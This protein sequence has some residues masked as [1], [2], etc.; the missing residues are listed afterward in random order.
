[1]KTKKLFLMMIA[2][3]TITFA[4][5]DKDN[6]PANEGEQ[7]GGN[8]AAPPL[9]AASTQTWTFGDQ[10]WSDAILC[11]DCN[12]EALE[13]SYTAP[14]CR[15]YT[16][17]GKTRDY[18]NWAYVDANKEKMCLSPWRVPTKE[19]FQALRSNTTYSTLVDAWGY[20]GYARESSVSGL[21]TYAHYWSSSEN[22]NNTAFIL[23]YSESGTLGV[24]SENKRYGYQVRCVK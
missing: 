10:T 24:I 13:D 21:S 2:A 7:D 22:S 6:D 19:D 14:R 4:G 9:A 5:C 11:P 1:M 15:S 18:Y 17:D 20:G 16:S 23:F 8:V 12:K 3:A